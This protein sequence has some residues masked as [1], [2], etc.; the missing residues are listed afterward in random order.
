MENTCSG[1]PLCEN[2]STKGSLGSCLGLRL[3]VL[4]GD[5][6]STKHTVKHTGA[7]G[8]MSHRHSLRTHMPP[9]VTVAQVRSAKAGVPSAGPVAA[10][11]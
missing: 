9:M 2:Q 1:E 7:S 11:M 10:L 4:T 5:Y 8:R 6:S 3:R